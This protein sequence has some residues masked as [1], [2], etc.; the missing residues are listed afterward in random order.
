[1]AGRKKSSTTKNADAAQECKDYEATLA[2]DFSGDVIKRLEVDKQKAIHLRRNGDNV[3]VCGP[4]PH[5]NRREA[6]TIEHA[7]SGVANVILHPAHANAGTNAL[8]H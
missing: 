1:M 5:E 2:T 6:S 4:N 8:N 7:A 3:V